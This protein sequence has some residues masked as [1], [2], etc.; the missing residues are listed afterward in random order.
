M[1]H[2]RAQ[3]KNVF[4]QPKRSSRVA[5]DSGR[6]GRRTEN[7]PRKAVSSRYAVPR[8]WR[9]DPVVAENALAFSSPPPQLLLGVGGTW[10]DPTRTARISPARPRRETTVLTMMMMTASVLATTTANTDFMIT[11]GSGV[12]SAYWQTYLVRILQSNEKHR[13][14]EIQ[15]AAE[16]TGSAS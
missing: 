7:C 8:R 5:E 16:T 1:A 4:T 15:C 3:R 14:L 13:V 9:P 6:G 10:L 2:V 12:V 11:C